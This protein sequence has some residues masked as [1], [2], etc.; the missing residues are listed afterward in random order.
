MSVAQQVAN[1]TTIFMHLLGACSVGNSG[2]LDDCSIVTHI[3]NNPDVTMI[4]DRKGSPE[5][6]IESRDRGALD[7]GVLHIIFLSTGRARIRV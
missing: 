7:A 3:V 6:F 4:E 2:G 1:Q 5:N